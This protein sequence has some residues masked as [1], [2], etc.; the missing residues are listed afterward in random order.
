[1]ELKKD[2]VPKTAENFLQLCTSTQ[3]GFGYKNSRFHR[4]SAARGS[5][6]PAASRQPC[7]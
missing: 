7:S 2:V 1:M 5:R 4:V 6:L 3:P